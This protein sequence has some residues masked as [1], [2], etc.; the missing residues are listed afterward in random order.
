[1]WTGAGRVGG[2]ALK[3][4]IGKLFEGTEYMF[5][6]AAENA[7]GLGEYTQLKKSVTAKLPFCKLS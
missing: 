5:R 7:I 3:A 2:S 1:M 4:K 6:V